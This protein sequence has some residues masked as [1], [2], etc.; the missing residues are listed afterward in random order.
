MVIKTIIINILKMVQKS[1][2]HELTK[3]RSVIFQRT[4]E[5]ILLKLKLNMEPVIHGDNSVIK[6]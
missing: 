1:S 2:F 5:I 3:M 4:E 6:N